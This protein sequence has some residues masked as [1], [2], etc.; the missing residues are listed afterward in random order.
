MTPR[1]PYDFG[2]AVDRSNILKAAQAAAEETTRRAWA[3]YAEAERAYRM[4]LAV[5][6]TRLKAGG[7]AATLAADLAR[8]DQRVA[9]LR[10]RRDVAEGVVEAAKQAGWRHQA[11]RRDGLEF[12]DWSKRRDLAE[13]Y[14]G[15]QQPAQFHNVTPERVR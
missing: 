12:I 10:Y 8:G 14:H 15:A 6:I 13:G 1:A 2:E 9:D 4:E 11:N 5:C 3:D 7:A